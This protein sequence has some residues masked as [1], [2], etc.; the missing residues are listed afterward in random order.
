MLRRCASQLAGRAVV[1]DLGVS[2][3]DSKADFVL[4]LPLAENLL[5]IV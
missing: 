3:V 5:Q 1:H 4:L 2:S